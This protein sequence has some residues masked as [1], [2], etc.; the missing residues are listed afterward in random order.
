MG[1]GAQSVMIS[2][3]IQMQKWLVGKNRSVAVSLIQYNV[4][5][6]ICGDLKCDKV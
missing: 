2:G 3:L 5:V 1:S 6:L 4:H